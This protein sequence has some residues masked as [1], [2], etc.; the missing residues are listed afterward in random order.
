MRKVVLSLLV[1]LVVAGAFVGPAAAFP[2][3]CTHKKPPTSP[4]P[5]PFTGVPLF[6]PVLLS[7]GAI[8]AGVAL[9]RRTREEF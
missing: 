4:G 8:G 7:L 5:L 2:R 9:R 1:A 3:C 6:V